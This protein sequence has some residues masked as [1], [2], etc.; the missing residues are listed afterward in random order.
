MVHALYGGDVAVS[1]EEDVRLFMHE[2]SPCGFVGAL[3]RACDVEHDDFLSCEGVRLDLGEEAQITTINIAFDCDRGRD[4]IE[5]IK[6][7]LVANITSVK[8]CSGALKCFGPCVRI[9]VAVCV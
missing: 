3:G 1:D 4:L 8:N 6:D 9:G 2:E 5:H 7:V